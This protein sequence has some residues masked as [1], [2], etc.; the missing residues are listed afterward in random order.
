MTD[1]CSGTLK[2]SEYYPM[3]NIAMKF[4][5][6]FTKYD[7]FIAFQMRMALASTAR[8]PYDEIIQ[9]CALH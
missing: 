3:A 5:Q 7:P 9:E 6:Y 2:P 4:V 8:R 1:E